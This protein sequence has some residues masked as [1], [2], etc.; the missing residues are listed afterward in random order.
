MI[1][2]ISEKKVR[3]E[4]A[5]AQA[6]LQ[7]YGERRTDLEGIGRC[8]HWLK[9][10]QAVD[11]FRRAAQVA[12]DP[13]GPD[14]GNAIWMGTI[15]GFAGEPTK[16]T[17]R[18]QQAYQIATQQAST[19]GLHG[20]IHLIKTC[21][22]LGYDAEAQTHVAT[23][24]ARGDQVPELEA[25]GILAQARQNQQIGLAQAAV[26]RLATLIRRERWQLSAT[27]APTPWD[28]Y[29]IALRLAK[30]LGADIPEEALP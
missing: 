3:K 23:L 1:I 22:L 24:H 27:R 12:P 2:T 5:E 4:L 28:W 18:L 14:A 9:D 7:E 20:Y 11:Y 26:D 30:D 21:V 29:E 13:R 15:W 17:K 10:P 8:L 19:G 6:R 25:L 16:A